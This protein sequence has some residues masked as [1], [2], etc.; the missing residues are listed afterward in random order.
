MAQQSLEQKFAGVS[1]MRDALR[2]SPTGFYVFPVPSE[3]TNWRDEQ[4]AWANTAVLFDQSYHMTD[5]YISGPDKVKLLSDLSI[6]DYTNFEPLTAAQFV[7]CNEQGFIIGDAI[8]FHLQDGRFNL[9][10]KP[11]AA[12]WVRFKAETGD[13]D[14]EL[15][16]DI[17]VV[18]GDSQRQTYRL[19]VQGPNAYKILEKTHG[20]PLPETRFFG[21]CEFTIAGHKVTALRHGMAGAPGMEFW[22]PYEEREAVRAALMEAGEEFG[23]KAGGGRVYSTAGPE[24]GW[25]GS[26]MPAIYE[27]DE[28]K[29]YREWLPA[30]GFEGML[31]IGGSLMSDNLE[32]YYLDP[33]DVGY[34]RLIH[35]D[36]EFVGRA[37][38]LAKKDDKHR[39]K[40]WL[41]WDQ[42]DVEKI[43]GSWYNG[44]GEGYKYLEAPAAHYATIP[45]DEVTIDGKKVG[46][47]VYAAFTVN[48]GS[49]FSIGIIDEDAVEF[50]KEVSITWGEPEGVTGKL[51]VEP[52]KQ[53]TIN[54][55]MCKTALG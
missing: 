27:G 3:H 26:V 1:N 10:G 25:V 13:Y 29:A 44:Y 4:W 39:R 33:W 2:N 55:V 16:V 22:G 37:A 23:L 47:S 14:V 32:D 17:R 41:R 35:W 8:V 30:G 9:V 48:A 43:Y 28:M 50:G 18:E 31:S 45:Y 51:T 7:A 24:S 54:A 20:G 6:N 36:H 12:N 19:Q 15:E 49:W 5:L 11:A 40:I 42:K 53:T 52:H 21:M 34:H 46:L 38:L